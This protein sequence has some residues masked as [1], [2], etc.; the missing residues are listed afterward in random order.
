[1]LMLMNIWEDGS[2]LGAQ[3]IAHACPQAT[4]TYKPTNQMESS[5]VSITM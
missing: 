3:T 2:I 5:S 4:H 1:M